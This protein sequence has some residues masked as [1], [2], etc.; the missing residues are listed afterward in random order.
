MKYSLVNLHFEPGDEQIAT[1][2][3]GF[4]T[5]SYRSAVSASF[6]FNDVAHAKLVLGTGLIALALLEEWRS[7]KERGPTARQ[8]WSARSAATET[9]STVPRLV[10]RAFTTSSGEVV[11]DAS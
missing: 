8:C 5:V 10:P 4:V 2:L 3:D 6:F 7:G 11:A 9:W 1:Q